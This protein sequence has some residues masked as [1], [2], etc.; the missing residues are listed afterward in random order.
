VRAVEPD[1]VGP[2]GRSTLEQFDL[3]FV[4]HRRFLVEQITA[5]SEAEFSMVS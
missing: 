1:E 2:S 3:A 4:L 5:A